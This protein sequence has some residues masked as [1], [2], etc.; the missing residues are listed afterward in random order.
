MR[1][2][3]VAIAIVAFLPGMN[4]RGDDRVA[5]L[6]RQR[7]A[8]SG[9]AWEIRE[10]GHPVMGRVRFAHLKLAIGTPVGGNRVYSSAYVSCELDDRTIAIEL[11]NQRAPDD[12]GGLPPARPPRLVCK[13][14]APSGSGITQDLLEAHWQYNNLGDALARGFK[15]STLRA[16]ASIGVVQEVALPPAWAKPSVSIDFEI[17]PYARAL[18]SVFASCGMPTAYAAA[19]ASGWRVARTVA[20][21]RTNVR[22]HPDI[23]SAVVAHLDPGAV[24]LVQRAGR[25]WWR[26]KSRN[27]DRFEGYIR[28]DRLSLQ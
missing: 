19:P 10:A 27:G 18:D 15:P 22:E 14:P 23:R 9:L 7:A 4:A 13:S 3:A 12:P 1:A 5:A 11:T 28:E 21:G 20:H 2:L 17:T 8:A 6:G 26:A 16:C 25:D 24:I